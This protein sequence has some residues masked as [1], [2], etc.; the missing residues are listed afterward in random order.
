[1]KGVILTLALTLVGCQQK[2]DQSVLTPDKVLL[3]DYEFEVQN[4][5]SENGFSSAGLK[6]KCKAEIGNVVQD[7]KFLKVDCFEGLD[8]NGIYPWSNFVSSPKLTAVFQEYLKNL[9]L[10]FQY[11]NGHVDDIM[12]PEHVS[13]FALNVCKGILNLYENT[14]KNDQ[15]TYNLKENGIEG[16]CD[17]TYLL[18]NTEKPDE[19][20]V[21]KSKDLTNCDNEAKQVVGAAHVTP[22]E[23]CRQKNRNFQGTRTYNYRMKDLKERNEKIILHATAQEIQQFTPFREETGETIIME[24]R[25]KLEFIEAHSRLPQIPSHLQKHG[26]LLYSFKDNPIL[27]VPLSKIK[28]RNKEIEDGLRYLANDNVPKDGKRFLQLVNLLRTEKE[29]NYSEVFDPFYSQ[30]K[31]RAIVLDL[32]SA[33]GTSMGLRYVRH[34][35]VQQEI[36]TTEAAQI[37]LVFF[38]YSNAFEEVVEEAMAIMIDVLKGP[39]SLYRT[40]ICLAY[41]SL[42]SRFYAISETIPDKYLKPLTD[43]ATKA[44]RSSDIDASV[45]ALKT[46]G[47][48]RHIIVLKPIMK[49][50][51]TADPSDIRIQQNAIMALRNPGKK[52]P[53]RVQGILLPIIKNYKI[54]PLVRTCAAFVLL[55]SKPTFPILMTLVNAMLHEPSIQVENFVFMYL[56]TIAGSRSPEFQVTASAYRTALKVLTEKSQKWA[57]YSVSRYSLMEYFDEFYKGRL[58][59]NSMF[60]HEEMNTQPTFTMKNFKAIFMGS[61]FS[62]LEI[63]VQIQRIKEQVNKGHDSQQLQKTPSGQKITTDG[64]IALEV[65]AKIFDQEIVTEYIKMDRIRQILQANREKG[66]LLWMKYLID[67]LKNLPN[68]HWQKYFMSAEIQRIVPTCTGLPWQIGLVHIAHTEVAGNVQLLMTPEPTSQITWPDIINSDIK[69]KTRLRLQI[70]KDMILN[71]G[72]ITPEIHALLEKKATFT[73]NIP[74]NMDVAMNIKEKTFELE[75]PPCKEETDIISLRLK[76]SAIT[77]NIE[78]APAAV[79]TPVFLP[80]NLS[81]TIVKS[82]DRSSEKGDKRKD[83]L[84]S[85]KKSAKNPNAQLEKYLESIHQTKCFEA[86]TFGCKSCF[87]WADMHAGCI[88]RRSIYNFIG[89]YVFKISLKES[90]PNVPIENLRFTI[91]GGAR[92]AEQM[93]HLLRNEEKDLLIKRLK[94]ILPDS[95]GESIE[96]SSS[97]DFQ[98]SG[99]K[100]LIGLKQQKE[101]SHPSREKDGAEKKRTKRPAEDYDEQELGGQEL[102]NLHFRESQI[103]QSG[104]PLPYSEASSRNDSSWQEEAKTP[105]GVLLPYVTVV[106]EAVRSD[107][108]NQGY[109]VSLYEKHDYRK[110]YFKIVANNLNQT[111]WRA[112]LDSLIQPI[113]FQYSLSWGH[114][115]KDYKIEV[116]LSKGQVAIYKAI[117]LKMKW[118]KL[119]FFRHEHYIGFMYLLP[120]VAYHLGFS[121]LYQKNPEREIIFRVIEKTP[122]IYVAIIKIPNRTFYNDDF[123]PEFLSS[124]IPSSYY[125]NP[126]LSRFNVALWLS[127][128]VEAVCEVQDEII[129]TFDNKIFNTTIAKRE[130]NLL[131]VK[132]C[133]TSDSY[134]PH[135]QIWIQYPTPGFPK[136]IHIAI[137]V[138]EITIQDTPGML[139]VLHNEA[140]IPTN[141]EANIEILKTSNNVNV[142]APEYGLESVTYDAEFRNCNRL[143]LTQEDPR[144]FKKILSAKSDSR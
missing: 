80:A 1:M 28:N 81:R 10:T 23:F 98:E 30:P 95:S 103:D 25:Q 17:T 35:I 55:E 87:H 54:D 49:Y 129:K 110:T 37:L 26:S 60:L 84:P 93:V 112:C 40:T 128:Q 22:C 142:K 41:G 64:S 102:A 133:T 120:A 85:E 107:N 97:S 7:Q 16:R 74:I 130:G 96:S 109:S 32:I 123:D 67:V 9:I 119:S 34:K 99:L 86:C 4:R 46:F 79:S 8:Y 50:L 144:R 94:K 33:A 27:P 38:H 13:E 42:L 138:T 12:V 89:E 18:Q 134:K 131:I 140:P 36:T 82:F 14:I 24:A 19:F 117:Q 137:N 91:R 43:F 116:K 113:G 45:L 92:V 66:H 118:T 125:Q 70:K 75:L 104:N 69:L 11:R 21:T 132:D 143:D 115:C 141:K 136:E 3:Y 52:D 139:T 48:V 2:I 100:K 71:M 114:E 68:I 47:N 29:I 63:G 83:T 73:A 57:G 108:K 76:T 6:V 53:I 31:Y 20:L 56:S 59:M 127:R 122:E 58:G 111:K 106:L 72:I 78:E 77:S 5:M 90:D 126:K 65:Y 44:I 121:T 62:P 101:K 124:G 88:V 39:R 105:G 61:I 15:K 51:Q 135:F